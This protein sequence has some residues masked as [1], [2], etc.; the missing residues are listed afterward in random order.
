MDRTVFYYCIS[1]EDNTSYNQEIN[2][3]RNKNIEE[4]FDNH[5]TM[6]T[7]NN[8]IYIISN[9]VTDI[10]EYLETTK[11]TI[12]ISD[13][14]DRNVDTFINKIDDNKQVGSSILFN[15][16]FKTITKNNTCVIKKK[17]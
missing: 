6:V 10:E 2:S 14:E 13:V 7:I 9:Y 15:N 4:I 17:N 16:Q 3:S 1:E 5:F 8:K 12:F 11:E